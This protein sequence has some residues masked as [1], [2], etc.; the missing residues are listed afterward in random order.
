M[1][2]NCAIGIL[3]FIGLGILLMVL[4]NKKRAEHH[5]YFVQ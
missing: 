4:K 1:I 5:L 3:T 2:M